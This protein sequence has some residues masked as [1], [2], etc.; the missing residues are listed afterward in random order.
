MLF[1]ARR[2]H[3]V[4]GI[5]RVDRLPYVEATILELQRYKTIVP[6]ALPHRTLKDTEIGGYFIPKGTTVSRQITKCT[7]QSSV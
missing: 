3:I 1:I 5:V 6:L 4:R 7:A 2:L